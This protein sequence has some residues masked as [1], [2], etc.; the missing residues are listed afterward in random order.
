M[1]GI[2]TAAITLVSSCTA[3]EIQ[4]KFE[5]DTLELSIDYVTQTVPRAALDEVIDLLCEMRNRMPPIE[6][7]EGELPLQ[8]ATFAEDVKVDDVKL[9]EGRALTND[10]VQA[11]VDEE[12]IRD[13]AIEK[14]EATEIEKS[15]ADFDPR[16]AL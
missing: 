14:E 7:D 8:N 13:Q 11:V 2:K 3:H 10:E 12:A 9:Y 15:K 4:A 16:A 6:D 1:T 5:M